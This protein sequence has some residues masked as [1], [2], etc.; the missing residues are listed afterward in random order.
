L[1]WP[2]TDG[3]KTL[4]IN[5]IFMKTIQFGYSLLLLAVITMVAGCSTTDDRDI[6]FTDSIAP[7]TDLK[8]LVTL[9]QDNSGTATFTPS[10]ENAAAFTIDFGD[11][12]EIAE[13][14]PGENTTH[15]YGEGV[16]SAVLTATNING[17]STQLTQE[18]VV[19]FLPPENLEITITQNANPFSISVSATADLAVSF[20]VTFGDDPMAEAVPFMTGE[21]VEHTYAAVGTYEVTV[22]A[23]SGGTN[24]IM[25]SET[26]VIE[27]PVTLPIDFESTT[28]N[29]N[30]I[31]FGGGFGS[32]IDNPDATGANTSAKVGEFFKE[33]G[34][35]IFAGTVLVLGAPIDFTTETSFSMNT[36]SPQAGITVKLKLEN[37]DDPNIAAEIDAVTTVTNEW[38]TL[39]FD[40]SG[41]DLTQEYSK[42]I[43]FFEFGET[44]SGTTY[45]FDNIQQ[46]VG[47]GSGGGNAATLPVTFDD[48]NITYEIFGFEGA[49]SAVEANAV[50]GGINTSPTVVRTIKTDG[51]AFFAGTVVFLD[52][53]IDFQ[54]GT[55]ISLKTYSP[56]VG[57]PVRLKLENE[58][59]SEFVE[60]DV[61]TTV[62]NE[63][64][65]LVWDFSGMGITPN[66]NKVVVF[67][68]FVVDLPGDGTTYYFD[69]INLAN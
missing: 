5:R 49:D 7:P 65:E 54:G 32:V 6:D 64:E 43:V 18:V 44:G 42:V 14:V 60:L 61:N 46:G 34:A 45:Y 27:N 29:Y 56:K 2:V 40:F 26:V 23:Y 35:E 12:S 1:N 59:G 68:E 66:F 58:D 24:F 36:W 25:A 63:W 53:T 30:F 38:E 48:P 67:F 10:G 22:R 9:S 21:S 57:I 52:G 39:S 55:K 11:G 28:I 17:E 13:L 69:D 50:S 41:A 31:N 8:M 19:S 51:A 4:D 15:M 37:L 16:F 33:D 62:A 47:G 20:D 3:N